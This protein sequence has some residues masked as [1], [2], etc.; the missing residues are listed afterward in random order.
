MTKLKQHPQT[1]TQQVG[2]WDTV[3][4]SHREALMRVES[5][6]MAYFIEKRSATMRASKSKD[7]TLVQSKFFDLS[8]GMLLWRPLFLRVLAGVACLLAFFSVENDLVPR[9]SLQKSSP[10]QASLQLAGF[11]L[12]AREPAKTNKAA[13]IQKVAHTLAPADQLCFVNGL[14]IYN[15]DPLARKWYVQNHHAEQLKMNC[16]M[17]ESSCKMSQPLQIALRHPERKTTTIRCY[18]GFQVSTRR[19][20]FHIQQVG[21]KLQVEVFRGLLALELQN[22]TEYIEGHGKTEQV[23]TPK[24]WRSS[25]S[26]LCS[27]HDTACIDYAEQESPEVEGEEVVLAAA[28]F[29]E[30]YTHNPQEQRLL[31][32]SF[33]AT[34]ATLL[35]GSQKLPQ[36]CETQKSTIR[37]DSIVNEKQKQGHSIRI[38]VLT[39]Q[40]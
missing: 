7:D 11:S 2:S 26:S 30:P 18:Q 34:N 17:T 10:F 4:P 33:A 20:N 21:P 32:A 37:H 3:P 25:P 40:G 1:N 28:S 24:G 12:R 22:K 19:A 9:A 38:S 29:Q 39:Q 8:G 35:Y 14:E 31:P 15:P 5:E 16:L 13:H 23:L 27:K 6:A 36:I